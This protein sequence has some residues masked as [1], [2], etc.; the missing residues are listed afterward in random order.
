M[1]RVIMTHMIHATHLIK[2]ALW[3]LSVPFLFGALPQYGIYES[4]HIYGKK[5]HV[6]LQWRTKWALSVPFGHFSIISHMSHVTHIIEWKTC[7]HCN[8]LQHT[9]THCNT[10]QHTATECSTLQ[11]SSRTYHLNCQLGCHWSPM[12]IIAMSRV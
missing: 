10:L 5:C 4:C 7:T 1:S 12:P 6:A 8:T 3:A 9:A 11:L 2:N